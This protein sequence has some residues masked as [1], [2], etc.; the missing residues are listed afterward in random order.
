MVCL[1]SIS[2]KQRCYP[3]D[4]LKLSNAKSR[5]A[6]IKYIVPIL[7]LLLERDVLLLKAP[8]RMWPHLFEIEPA[9]IGWPGISSTVEPF[10]DGK[11]RNSGKDVEEER[12]AHNL[13]A[14][15]LF[16]LLWQ[17]HAGVDLSRTDTSKL[18]E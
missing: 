6:S 10:A 9:E 2:G 16:A 1:T 14:K 17:T 4:R 12:E 5:F 15:Q 11:A 3:I 7:I 8:R 13:Y 18:W